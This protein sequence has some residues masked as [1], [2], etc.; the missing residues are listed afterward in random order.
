MSDAQDRFCALWQDAES[1]LNAFIRMMAPNSSDFD[2]IVQETALTAFRKFESFDESQAS[3][4]TWVRGIAKFEVLNRR[5][6]YARSKIMF[7]S[8]TIDLLEGT[9]F[10]VEEE[11]PDERLDQL[12]LSMGELDDAQRKMLEMK[13]IHGYDSERI[14]K[15]LGISAGNAR[16]RLM[17][18]RDLLFE[19]MIK[20]EPAR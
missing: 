3:F 11:K 10:Q 17:R 5:R 2:D 14:G 18:I 13:Y 8:E 12:K 7:S 6:S 1:S 15:E 16:I 9:A 19:K 4:S 20:L